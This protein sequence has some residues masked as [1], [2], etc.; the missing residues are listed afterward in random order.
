M[1]DVLN[2]Q[3]MLVLLKVQ[4]RRERI[5]ADYTVSRPEAAFCGGNTCTAACGNNCTARCPGSCQGTCTR[6]CQGKMR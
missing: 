5:P 1:N 6:S 2:E 3:M 4:P